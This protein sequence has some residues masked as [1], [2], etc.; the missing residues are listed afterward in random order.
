MMKNN[1]V[2]ITLSTHDADF[3]AKQLDFLAK[4]YSQG[5]FRSRELA[6]MI[7]TL[8]IRAESR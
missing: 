8:R 4:N 3:I 6:K 5:S 7:D 2:T 1:T